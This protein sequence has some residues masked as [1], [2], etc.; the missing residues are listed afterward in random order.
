[1]IKICATEISKDSILQSFVVE[2]DRKRIKKG[3]KA[4]ELKIIARLFFNGKLISQ[5]FYNVKGFERAVHKF[6]F[7]TIAREGSYSLLAEYC[8]DFR[9]PL[10]GEIVFR[11]ISVEGLS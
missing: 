9:P 11:D 7:P 2:T 4:R 8:S 6:G 3:D 5:V 10:I 1:M